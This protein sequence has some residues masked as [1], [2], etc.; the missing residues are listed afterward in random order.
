MPVIPP[1]SK[2]NL[3][4]L[5]DNRI[6]PQFTPQKKF[7]LALVAHNRGLVYQGLRNLKSFPHDGKK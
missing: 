3:E 2:T 1:F 6:P 7:S 5:S 4:I